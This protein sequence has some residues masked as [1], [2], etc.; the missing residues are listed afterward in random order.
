MRVVAFG[1]FLAVVSF[2]AL[3]HIY[4][5]R[6]EDVEK[7]KA[8]GAA[9]PYER[10]TGWAI[11]EP[12]VKIEMEY[13]KPRQPTQG[14]GA[15]VL[16]TGKSGTY[17]DLM[18]KG[19][20]LIR[21]QTGDAEAIREMISFLRYGGGPEAFLLGDQKRFVKRA[22]VVGDAA[23]LESILPTNAN[24]QNKRLFDGVIVTGSKP[25]RAPSDVRSIPAKSKLSESVLDLDAQLSPVAK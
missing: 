5:D 17:P 16:L 10:I 3:Q 9:G 22:I 18:Q 19:F 1:L 25:Y 15:L 2:G 24:A 14:N 21:L 11:Y 4:V 23:T 7:G 20:I 6:R 8:F 13:L 12:Q